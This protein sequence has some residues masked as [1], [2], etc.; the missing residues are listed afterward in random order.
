MQVKKRNYLNIVLISFKRILNQVEQ[1]IR[2]ETEVLTDM[3]SSKNFH[4][5]LVNFI[6]SE[7]CLQFQNPN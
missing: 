2:G 3:W 4:V 5:N 1:V 7:K 6:N